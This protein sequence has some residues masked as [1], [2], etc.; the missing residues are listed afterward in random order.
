M[1]KGGYMGKVLRV[2]LTKKTATVEP[3]KER[4]VEMLLGGR[5]L[6]AKRY[7]DEIGPGVRPFDAENKVFFF[8]GPLTGVRLPST[9]KFQLATKSP[10]TGMYLCSNCGGDFGPQLKKAGYDGLIVEGK[11]AD[12]TYLSLKGDGSGTLE[13]LRDARP[14]RA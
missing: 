7:Y 4:E 11:A 2:N 14:G 8:T 5:G 13:S 9:T 1:F 3:L 6:A 12:W 10:E